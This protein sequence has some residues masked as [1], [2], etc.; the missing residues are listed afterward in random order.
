M[1]PLR[2]LKIHFGLL[3]HSWRCGLLIRRPL[4]GLAEALRAADRFDFRLIVFWRICHSN[5]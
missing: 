1:S 2:G 5:A 3:T 4:R